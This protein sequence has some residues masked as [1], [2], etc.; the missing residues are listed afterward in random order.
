MANA[1]PICKCFGKGDR[2]FQSNTYIFCSCTFVFILRENQQN[3]IL[4]QS[5]Q[6]MFYF[7]IL[8]LSSKY[9]EGFP[10]FYL[11]LFLNILTITYYINNT[12]YQYHVNHV[13]FTL[14]ERNP[15]DSVSYNSKRNSANTISQSDPSFNC[16]NPL[17]FGQIKLNNITLVSSCRSAGVLDKK[18]IYSHSHFYKYFLFKLMVIQHVICPG[19]KMISQSQI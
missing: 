1:G 19:L 7:I 16:L 5:I 17:Q 13:H 4:L 15:L 8:C 2:R 14:T 12:E 10:Q 6:S 18:I 3:G 11:R 9:Y